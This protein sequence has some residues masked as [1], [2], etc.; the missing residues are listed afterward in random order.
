MTNSIKSRVVVWTKVEDDKMWD[1]INI[2]RLFIDQFN[3][4][5]Q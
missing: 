3:S 1:D 4:R 2:W 5:R